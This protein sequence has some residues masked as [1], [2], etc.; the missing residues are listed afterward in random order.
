MAGNIFISYRRGDDPGFAQAIYQR[1]E[2]EF[3]GESLFMD[4]EGHI[5]P[6]DDFVAVLN[7]QVA[8]CD[9]LLAIIGERWIGARDA[10]GNRRLEKVDDF[11]RI[12]IASALN[13][14]K[15]VIPVLVNQAEMPRA[16]DLPPS[17]K[18]LARR[19]AVAIRPTRFKADSQG[20]ISALKEALALAEAD[21][22]AKSQAEPEVAEAS[23]DIA[24]L[25]TFRRDWPD[26]AHAADAKTRI[27]ELRGGH[28]TRRGVLKGVGIGTAIT[29][30]GGSVVYSATV[31]GGLIWRQIHDQ[32]LRSF[33]GHTASVKS[34]AFSPDGARALSASSDKTLKLWDVASGRELRAFTGHTAGVTT[35][36]FSPDGT[37]ALSGS[38]DETLK[39]WDVANG[40]ELRTF[41]DPNVRGNTSVSYGLRSILGLTHDATSVAFSPDGAH[42]LSA[43]GYLLTLWDVASEHEPRFFTGHT[44]NVTSVVFSSDGAHALSGSEDMTLKL[45][46]VA[47]GHELRNFAGHTGRVTSVA[48]S[49][50]GARAL[51]GSGDKT[52]RLWDIV[53]GLGLDTFLGHMGWVTSVALSPDGARALSGS[54]DKTLKL[55]EVASGRE[56]HSFTGHTSGITSV[57]FSPDGTRALSGSDDE[58]L[59]L[60]DLSPWLVAQ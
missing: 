8:Q 12:E 44:N 40:R 43:G 54:D 32:S 1:L 47:S 22:A 7:R 36:V 45:W 3:P 26:G 28:F 13:L 29:A 39:L 14:G 55:W 30:A 24:A 37:R 10:D 41:K 27:R 11:V 58:T 23:A 4:V 25:Q 38:H 34:L 20:L 49:P 9:V 53:N 17:L 2:Q 15:R 6:G 42:A 18:P 5:K 57:A 21:R 59:K 16:G 52:L 33:T 31:P 50:D 51:S 35:V 46:D 48:F 19:N 56:L 60:W